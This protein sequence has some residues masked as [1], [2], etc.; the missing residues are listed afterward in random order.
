MPSCAASC[1][2]AVGNDSVSIFRECALQSLPTT[3]TA[4][5]FCWGSAIFEYEGATFESHDAIT[6]P[7]VDALSR[8]PGKMVTVQDRLTDRQ[9]CL[10]ASCQ[11]S[12]A[13]T[14]ALRI[15]YSMGRGEWQ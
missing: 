8:L 12:G 5:H 7:L 10:A 3:L 11:R 2:V 14:S 6:R 1:V 4:L 9:C 13:A 15:E